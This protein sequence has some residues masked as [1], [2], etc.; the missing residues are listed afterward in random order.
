M[1]LG[2]GVLLSGAAV[3]LCSDEANSSWPVPA[4]YPALLAIAKLYEP[5][6]RFFLLYDT[7]FCIKVGRQKRL[8][9]ALYFGGWGTRYEATNWKLVSVHVEGIG[10][11]LVI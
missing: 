3:L 2:L 8:F 7:K 11:S 10:F 1:L 6:R 9:S 4:F 5:F